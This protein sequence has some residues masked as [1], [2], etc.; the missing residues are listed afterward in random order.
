MVN[1]QN[2]PPESAD[3]NSG[4]WSFLNRNSPPP[5]MIPEPAARSSAE[6]M[7]NESL[8]GIESAP[9]AMPSAAPSAPL[10]SLDPDISCTTCEVAGA[11]VVRYLHAGTGQHFQFGAAEHYVAQLL[12]GQRGVAEIVAD[13]EEAGLEWTPKDVADFIG[14]L[15]AQ[16]LAITVAA[17]SLDQAATQETVVET[18]VAETPVVEEP[19]VEETVAEESAEPVRELDSDSDCRLDANPSSETVGDKESLNAVQASVDAETI[20]DAETVEAAEQVIDADS[21]ESAKSPRRGFGETTS[22]YVTQLVGWVSIGLAGLTGMASK[23]LPT[24]MKWCSYAISIRIP[25]LVANPWAARIL[26]VVR[27]L[28]SGGGMIAACLFIGTSLMFASYHHAALADE[29]MRIFNSRLGIMMF[30]VWVILKVIHEFGHACTA[31]LHDV[32]VG[33][34]GVTFFMFAP[35][36]YVDVTDAWKLPSRNARVSIAMGGVYFELICASIAVWVWWW[37][38]GGL[39]AHI[40]AQVFFLAGPATLLV[41]ANPLLRLDGYYVVSDLVD[42][43]NLREQGR[44]LLGGL[45][46]QRLFGMVAPKTHLTGWRRTFAIVHAFASVVFQFVWM[47]GLVV[48]VSMWAGPFGL[49]IAGCALFLWTVVPSVR[50]AHKLWTYQEESEHFSV[51]SH[52]R[53]VMWSVLTVA[54]VAQFFITLPSPLIVEVPAVTRFANDQVLRAPASGFISQVYFDSGQTVRMGEVILEIE[55]AELQVKRD[56]IALELESEAIQWQRHERA[57][58][59]GL[60]EGSTRRTESLKRKLSELDEQVA[61]MKVK[62]TANGEILTHHLENMAGRYVSHGSELVQIGNRNR[63]ELLLTIGDSE[64]DAY[65]EA[66]ERGHVLRVCFRGGQWV[67][68]VP[69]PMRPRAS[70]NVPH[71]A[72]AATAGGPVPVSPSRSDSDNGPKVEFLTPRFEAVVQLAPG[73]SDLVHCGEVGHLALQDKRSLA[74]R[75][76]MWLSE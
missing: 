34:A 32:R 55:N 31:K 50:W 4:G 33:K 56:E 17:P 26:P 43:P 2:T 75:F 63:K 76:W 14:M 10:V 11:T 42:V 71:P 18:P 12:D 19:V 58:A 41:N 53:R 52:R 57:Q 25:L 67:D 13:A 28:L 69:K 38:S 24:I 68:V 72:L 1:F 22:Q 8:D 65:N 21:L 74:H 30:G 37:M 6:Q 61:A 27:P 23:L 59:L 49:L 29:L 36:A 7:G 47:T 51:G 44:R 16:K 3:E 70:L 5:A 73:Q 64:M 39:T 45:I 48:V 35:I 60:A 9:R 20:D 15:V 62:A 54:A 66:V 46:E 40:A